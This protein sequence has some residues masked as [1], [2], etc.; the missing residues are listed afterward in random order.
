[1]SEA[2]LRRESGDREPYAVIDIG[3]NSV[4]L[5]VAE[6]AGGGADGG[7]PLRET[8][9]GPRFVPLSRDLALTRLGEGLAARGELGAAAMERT[10]SA[11]LRFVRQ[12]EA[13]G[14]GGRI[15]LLGT[16]ALREASNR[17]AF[18]ER[19]GPVGERLQVISG[20]EEARLAFY[21]AVAG[22]PHRVRRELEQ[23]QDSLG[24][25]CCVVADV[26]GGSTEVQAGTLTGELRA[27]VSL[28][29]G[30][31]R[32]TEA[33]NLQDG[34][35]VTGRV[36][37][38]MEAEVARALGPALRPVV[39]TAPRLLVGVGG[40]ATSYA[41]MDLG[42]PAYDPERVHGHTL[43]LAR[44]SLLRSKLAA[45]PAA[46]RRDIPGL[47]PERADVIVAG[48]VILTVLMEE[49]GLTRLVVSEADLLVGYLYRLAA[50]R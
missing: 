43:S 45:L 26:G 31:V 20:E 34:R 38:E 33:F 27:G 50:R 13:L 46:R 41:A 5:L 23:T 32:L 44:V 21:G 42:L 16:S 36:L 40:T 35:V 10:A 2:P 6:L 17:Q 47:Q 4:R 12:A 22:L 7:A 24:E 28:P 19:L 11:V 9:G 48:G 25:P 14:A 18:I 3:T 30:V 39:A 37:A 15:A 8:Y 29:V 49:V 1:M